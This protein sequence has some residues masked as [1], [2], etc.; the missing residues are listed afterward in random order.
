MNDTSW[1]RVVSKQIVGY[2]QFY[3][4]QVSDVHSYL[5]EGIWHHNSGKTDTCAKYMVDHVR[6][7]ACLPGDTP[8]WMGIIAPTLGDAATS[9]FSGPSGISA[10]D[11]T[12]RMI[13]TIGGTVVRW[14]NG[15]EAKLFGAHTEED[16]QRLRSGGN[17]SIAVGTLIQTE[18]GPV[19]IEKV[20]TSDRVWTRNGLRPVLGSW[21]HGM[22]PLWTLHTYSGRKLR[23]T[24]DHKMW[25]GRGWVRCDQLTPGDTLWLYS[26]HGG[27]STSSNKHPA[28]SHVPCAEAISQSGDSGLPSLASDAVETISPDGAE[29]RVW[30]LTVAGEHEFF[31]NDLIARNCLNWLEELAAW[32]YIDVAWAQMRFGLRSGPH[33]HWIGSTT[34]KLRPLIK[35]LSKGKISNVVV[36]RASTYDNPHLPEEIRQAL[37]DEYGGTELG[38]QEL[39]GQLIEEVEGALWRHA[40]ID[41]A[42]ILADAVPDLSRIC[43][44][45]DPSGGAGEQGIV[46]A[47]RSKLALASSIMPEQPGIIVPASPRP[48]H[49]GYVLDDRTVHTTPNG[50]G[51]AAVQAARDWDADEI[52]VEA[53]YGGDMAIEVVRG[54]AEHLGISIPIRK[55]TASRGKAVRAAPVAALTSQGRWHHAGTFEALEDQMCSWTPE[56][57]YSP[58]RLDSAIW[59]AHGL[60]LAHLTG[61]GMGSFGGQMAGHVVVP[62][63]PRVS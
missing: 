35:R 1:K 4:L 52:L 58:D 8:H 44:G 26:G 39:L 3:D 22:R 6:G 13:N 24:P 37:E 51:R 38:R 12:A 62:G 46:V 31:A 63:R 36:T 29:G 20:T 19:P 41:A 21:D 56:S 7:P 60:R 10:H 16:T 55:I 53:N 15:S 33:P 27:G 2:G 42:R 57:D 61:A 45:V 18:R 49:Q 43:V 32:R 59:N 11:S 47:G 28:C 5:A 54:A 23:L 48:Q 9:C 40:T 30:D 50:W 25:T 34:P 14:P 17:R